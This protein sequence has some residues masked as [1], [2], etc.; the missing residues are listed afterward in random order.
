M[1]SVDR[2]VPKRS[3]A[4]T[5]LAMMML[6]VEARLTNEGAGEMSHP[7]RLGS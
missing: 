5:V 4:I 6:I 2:I 1:E 3:N 7:V